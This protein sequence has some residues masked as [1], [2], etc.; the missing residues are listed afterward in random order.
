MGVHELHLGQQHVR[1]V[2]V[3][4]G[5]KDTSI[6]KRPCQRAEVTRRL[7]IQHV[8]ADGRGKDLQQE[9]LVRLLHA[10]EGPGDLHQL[11]G[12]ATLDLLFQ[13]LPD[14]AE[15]PSMG[16]VLARKGPQDRGNIGHVEEVQRIQCLLGDLR[17]GMLV[18]LLQPREGRGRTDEVRR[19]LELHDPLAH[20]V[21][22]RG[23]ERRGFRCGVQARGL[24][25]AGCGCAQVP[26]GKVPMLV[27]AKGHQL[28]KPR[29]GQLQLDHGP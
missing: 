28:P 18:A 1:Q 22:Q 2:I 4:L 24:A 11:P 16:E 8:L 21:K 6:A 13:E 25:E 9:L 12:V 19:R 3:Q 15:H 26:R 17:K 29:R 5:I 27:Q 14:L 7:E 23:L 20:G 10:R